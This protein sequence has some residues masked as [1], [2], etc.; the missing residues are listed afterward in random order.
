MPFCGR[1]PKVKGEYR[2]AAIAIDRDDH[3]ILYA[4]TLCYGVYKSIDGG[5]NWKAVLPKLHCRTVAVGQETGHVYAGGGAHWWGKT[6]PG[7]WRSADKGETWRPLDVESL[8]NKQVTVIAPDPHRPA[9]LYV[10]TGGTGLF[11]GE[12]RP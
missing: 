12:P 10:G 11:V 3:N 2:M 4:G 8:G 7:I 5:K 9:R 1:L 6:N